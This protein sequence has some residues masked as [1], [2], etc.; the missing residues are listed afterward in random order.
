VAEQ[1]QI[2]TFRQK[3]QR[4][5]LYEAKVEAFTI[6]TTKVEAFT[7]STTIKKGIAKQAAAGSLKSAFK[8]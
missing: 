1:I 2:Q 8:S 4:S 6:S 7:I 3:S 5:A